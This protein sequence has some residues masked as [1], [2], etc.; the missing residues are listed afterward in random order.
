MSQTGRYRQVEER[1]LGVSLLEVRE[2]E[3]DDLATPRER[4]RATEHDAGLSIW[5]DHVSDPVVT[6]TRDGIVRHLRRRAFVIRLDQRTGKHYP[7]LRTFHHL[8]AKSLLQCS[9]DLNGRCI[10]LRF[11]QEVANVSNPNGG[12]YDFDRRAR[13]PYLIGKACDLEIAKLRAYL[14]AKG[15]DTD[16]PAHLKG[17]ALIEQERRE[18]CDFQRRDMYAAPLP[19]Y[20]SCAASGS[21]LADGDAVAFREWDGRLWLGTAY[22]NINNMWWVLLPG[23]IVRNLASFQLWPRAEQPIKAG[24]SFD[25]ERLLRRLESL[26]QEAVKA[27]R[28]ERAA[29]LRDVM[30]FIPA[31][32]LPSTRGTAHPS[33]EF[34]TCVPRHREL[35]PS[36]AL[37]GHERSVVEPTPSVPLVVGRETQKGNL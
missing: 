3:S 9:L 18:L 33:P 26:K 15:I 7:T 24:R 28:F 35:D 14:A 4:A 25:R 27:E 34:V 10:E 19:S 12:R 8:G 6:K 2:G 31:Q 11:W 29:V 30:K 36:P 32:P 13:M 37:R 23:G 17:L 20:N 1:R 22:H 16:R 21:L 5:F